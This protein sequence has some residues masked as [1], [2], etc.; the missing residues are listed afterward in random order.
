MAQSLGL[1]WFGPTPQEFTQLYGTVTS[2]PPSYH[3]AEAAGALF[4]LADA[5][6]RANSLNTSAVRA[7]L[8]SMHVMNFFGQFQV[9]ARGLQV[10]HSMV[11]VQWHAGSLKVTYPQAVAESPVQYPYTGG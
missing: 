9:N 5:I 7:A 6:H 4:V 10:A 2:T 1:D 8:G 11:V 3:S